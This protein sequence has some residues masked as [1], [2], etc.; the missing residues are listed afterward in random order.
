M[1][2]ET[3]NIQSKRA[4]CLELEKRNFN[5]DWG[6]VAVG[7]GREKEKDQKELGILWH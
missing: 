1:Q 6:V 7:A 5:V 3:K 4:K 2:Q